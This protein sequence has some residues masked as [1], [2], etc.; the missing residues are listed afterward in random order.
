MIDRT[1][2]PE[3]VN[4]LDADTLRRRLNELDGERAAVMALLRA[5]R[6]R[7]RTHDAPA[8]AARPAKGS[9]VIEALLIP[10]T[11]AAAMIG[12]LRAHFHRLRAAGKFGPPAIRLGRKVMYERESLIRWVQVGCPDAATWRA[13]EAQSRRLRVV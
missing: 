12:V 5:A 11:E 9:A 10:N 3:L 2:L 13:M 8:Q 7:E 1:T 4:S 6:A